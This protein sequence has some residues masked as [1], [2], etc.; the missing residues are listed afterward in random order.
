ME[1]AEGKGLPKL[2]YHLLPRTKGFT[3]TLK[4]LKGT[5]GACMHVLRAHT[6]TH[7][8]FK[9]RSCIIIDFLFCLSLFLVS[10][11][12]DVTLNFKDHQVPTLLGIIN[13]KKY[14]A[15]MRIRWVL[16]NM[17]DPVIIT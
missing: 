6:Y 13:G 5:G 9:I 8:Q 4:C 17:Y 10:A 16:I 14:L 11:V 12:Y 7:A 3:T 15:D 2:K 1:V